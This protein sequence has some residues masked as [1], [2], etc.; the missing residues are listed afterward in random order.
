MHIVRFSRF[1]VPADV[2][3]LVDGP[4][5][6]P[7]QAGE[8][9]VEVTASGQGIDVD[10]RDPATL[11]QV[12]SAITTIPGFAAGSTVILADWAWVLPILHQGMSAD[13]LLVIRHEGAQTQAPSYEP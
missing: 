6:A 10:W 8:A 5:P 2:A 1:G 13:D 4:E 3:E 7:P 11:A 9:L 12:V